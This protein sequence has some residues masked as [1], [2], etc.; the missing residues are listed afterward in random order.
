MDRMIIRVSSA[1]YCFSSL[2]GFWL[3]YNP[4]NDLPSEVIWYMQWWYSQP[5]TDFQAALGQLGVVAFIISMISVVV[6]AFRKKWAGYVFLISTVFLISAEWLLPNYA[7]QT[8][9]LASVENFALISM[10]AIYAVFLMSEKLE[11]FK[12]IEKQ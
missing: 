3:V 6:L 2:I 4:K 1:I 11:T 7:P 12:G 9:L 8:S 5:Q 10:G